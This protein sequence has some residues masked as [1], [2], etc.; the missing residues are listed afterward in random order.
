MTEDP[1]WPTEAKLRDLVMESI[2]THLPLARCSRCR[3]PALDT[4]EQAGEEVHC[5]ACW[6]ALGVSAELPF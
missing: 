2:R 5:Q 3:A 4:R 6:H 1:P